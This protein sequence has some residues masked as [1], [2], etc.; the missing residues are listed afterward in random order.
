MS[1]ARVLELERALRRI[2]EGRHG[3][4]SAAEMALLAWGALGIDRARSVPLPTPA[5]S[6]VPQP[7]NPF[8]AGYMPPVDSA[9]WRWG[10]PVCPAWHGGTVHAALM[11]AALHFEREPS[12]AHGGL[13]LPDYRGTAPAPPP[14]GH[15]GC[16]PADRCPPADPS[17]GA[18]S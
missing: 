5:A 15:Y 7:R 2:N 8:V 17:S 9:E 11:A 1:A 4:L 14:C 6:N 18:G 16:T 13:H 3:G 10:C 12:H